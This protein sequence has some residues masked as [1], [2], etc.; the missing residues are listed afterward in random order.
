MC[1][2]A[3]YFCLLFC[4]C[5]LCVQDKQMIN[6]LPAWEMVQPFS[7]PLGL[8]RCGVSH[9]CCGRC[10]SRPAATVKDSTDILDAELFLSILPFIFIYFIFKFLYFIPPYFMLLYTSILVQI[11]Y[12]LNQWQLLEFENPFFFFPWIIAWDVFNKCNLEINLH[13]P[14]AAFEPWG[15]HPPSLRLW[16]SHFPAAEGFGDV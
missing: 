9:L 4:H 15:S 12:D 14:L 2:L 10:W 3:R 6:Q 11:L 7:S 16:F 8:W 13:C 1:S 5:S